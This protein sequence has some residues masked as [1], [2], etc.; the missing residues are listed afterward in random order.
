MDKKIT[1]IISEIENFSKNSELIE[2]QIIEELK[3]YFHLKKIN[4]IVEL[5][6]NG[7][8]KVKEICKDFKIS[9]KTLY[10]ALKRSKIKTK[11]DI[12]KRKENY[13]YYI[14]RQKELKQKELN[15]KNS[16]K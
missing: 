16:K 10:K 8:K 14:N 15:K 7:T 11:Y 5:Y 4:E 9:P 12:F 3:E 2:T 13:T 6:V 1:E